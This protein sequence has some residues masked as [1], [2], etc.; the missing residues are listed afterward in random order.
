MISSLQWLQR[1][2]QLF[3]RRCCS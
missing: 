1:Y 2:I 3:M